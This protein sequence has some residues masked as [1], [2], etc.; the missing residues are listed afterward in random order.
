MTLESRLHPYEE[1]A[2]TLRGV[3]ERN[4]FVRCDVPACN[5]GS[6]HARHG[7]PE[8]FRELSDALKDAGVLNN[9]TGNLAS[10]ALAKLIEQRDALQSELTEWRAQSDAAGQALA[11]AR[12]DANRAMA[13]RDEARAQCVQR[14][15]E[16]D[17]ATGEIDRLQAVAQDELSR[18]IDHIRAQAAEV[19]ALREALHRL[20]VSAN[21]VAYCYERRP[22][23]FAVALQTLKDDATAARAALSGSGEG[24]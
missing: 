11:L 13:E 22:G 2:D 1:T 5:C 18:S 4:G 9:D 17:A 10:R 16:F 3:L 19:A 8:R 15:T 24:K 14:G 21:T 6:W 20:E 7:Y 12:Q 23:N